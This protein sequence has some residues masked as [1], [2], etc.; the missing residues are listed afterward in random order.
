M[1][2]ICVAILLSIV[3]HAVSVMLLGNDGGGASAGQT[4][5]GENG[6]PLYVRLANAAVASGDQTQPKNSGSGLPLPV[7]RSSP[8][9]RSVAQIQLSAFDANIDFPQEIYAPASEI[10]RAAEM[11]LPYDS[12]LIPGASGI[13]GRLRLEIKV[14]RHGKVREVR[15]LDG[16]D[17]GKAMEKVIVPWLKSSP[18]QPGRNAGVAVNSLIQIDLTLVPP[19]PIDP[20]FRATRP[21]GQPLWMDDKGKFINDATSVSRPR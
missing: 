8:Q 4:P 5:D 16:V 6:R 1:P 12:D 21:P 2:T 15:V 11:L 13:T 7:K 17:P 18:F 9:Q 3:L 14:D 20:N 10:Q 19:T